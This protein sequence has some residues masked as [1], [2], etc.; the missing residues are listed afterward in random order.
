MFGLEIPVELE[1][2]VLG[3][4]AKENGWPE[5]WPAGAETVPAYGVWNV[6]TRFEPTFFALVILLDRG[7]ATR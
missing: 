4:R 2:S 3:S 1:R 6:I 7:P 5:C